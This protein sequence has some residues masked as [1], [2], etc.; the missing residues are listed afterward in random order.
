MHPL[1]RFMPLL[2]ALALILATGAAAAPPPGPPILV[3]LD[4]D[5]SSGSARSGEA[6]R[7]GALLAVEDVNRRGGVLGRPLQLVVRDHR[8]NPARGKDNMREFSRM[9]D[10]S[11]VVGGLHTPVALAEL[12]MIHEN[13]IIYLVPWAAGTPVVENGFHPNYVFRVSVRD[14]AAGGFLVGK[15]L[16]MGYR[17]P[18]LLLERTG[19][20]RSNERSMKKAL[21]AA[22]S[23][24]ATVQWFHWGCR[25]VSRQLEAARKKGA[26][27]ILLVANAPEGVAVVK[28]MADL[29]ESA[30]LPI[31]SHW[32]ITGGDFYAGA[33]KSRAFVDLVFLQTYSFLDPPF[34]EKAE[35]FFSRYRERF[36]EAETPRDIFAP[37]GTAHAWDLVHLL[38]RAIEEAGTVDG[39]AVRDALE[40]LK[41]HSGLV[42]R[43]RPPFAPGRHDALTAADYR[44]ARYDDR[45][46]IVPLSG[47][48]ARNGE[49]EGGRR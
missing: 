47:G 36:P 7:R 9:K 8:G 24:P 39:P 48:T 16:E 20:G 23:A 10:L 11:A 17:K 44:L 41:E 27:V 43:Y 38:A 28:S 3:G 49:H 26:D 32:G 12:D 25:G 45:G 40:G 34:P 30:R 14:E 4:A 46:V 37:V 2:G 33:G 35:L 31:I 18:A 5:M 22:G 1:K 19:W 29:P 6:I 21:K 42:R 13:R 15:A